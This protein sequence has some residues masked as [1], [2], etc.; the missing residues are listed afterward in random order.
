MKKVKANLTEYREVLHMIEGNIIPCNYDV[1]KKSVEYKDI[2][3]HCVVWFKTD[4]TGNLYEGKTSYLS[5]GE[6]ETRWDFH[7]NFK[8]DL[9]GLRESMRAKPKKSR[10]KAKAKATK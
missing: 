7:A 2:T 1:S 9:V 3:W 4:A 6:I 10:K 5:Q 8:A